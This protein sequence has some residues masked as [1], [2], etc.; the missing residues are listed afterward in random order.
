[1]PV[2]VTVYGLIP[3]LQNATPGAYTDSITATVTF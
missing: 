2:L 3:T 1:M